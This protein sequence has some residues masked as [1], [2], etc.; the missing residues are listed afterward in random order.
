[1]FGARPLKRTIQREVETPIAKLLLAGGIKPGSC[2]LLDAKPGDDRI[3][4]SVVADAN[5]SPSEDMK[6][7]KDM[8]G[9]EGSEE[10]KDA[11]DA[12]GSKD[13]QDSKVDSM[14]HVGVM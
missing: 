8:K 1:M 6:G 3:D 4:I 5:Y 12:K 7:P 11:K 13:S 14:D 10:S 2:F 9:S